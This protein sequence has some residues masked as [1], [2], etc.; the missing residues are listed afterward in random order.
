MNII[1][2]CSQ[3]SWIKSVVQCII[4]MGKKSSFDKGVFEPD[5]SK[6]NK[7]DYT[8]LNN[9]IRCRAMK[10]AFS[11]VTLITL[12]V[13]SNLSYA[14]FYYGA[15]IGPGDVDVPGYDDAT[16]IRMQMGQK[17]TVTGWEFGFSFGSYD[18]TGSGGTAS[19]DV[20][21]LDMNFMG[22]LPI[23]STVDA[24]G[25]LG[26]TI[27]NADAVAYGSYIVGSDDGAGLT[28]GLGFDISMSP[29]WDMRIEFQA[30]PDISDADITQT[31]IGFNYHLY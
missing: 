9:F 22:Y 30:L 4:N 21:E 8:V 6:N 20:S 17:D 11:L 18:V 16:V 1:V 24:F 27:W 28:Y 15:A 5:A 2:V 14:G 31:L 26:V 10:K 29:Q 7:T 19:V 13:L 3:V 25:R 23:T 12:L